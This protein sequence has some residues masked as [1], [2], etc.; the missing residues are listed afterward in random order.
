MLCADAAAGI[1]AITAAVA[2]SRADD[3]SAP[4]LIAL[5]LGLALAG[6]AF[7]IT[8]GRGLDVSGSFLSIV[9]AMALV[10][11]TGAV[12]VGV[13][14]AFVDGLRQRRPVDSLV[15]N[16]ATYAAFPHA[17]ALVLQAATAPG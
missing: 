11:P 16:V 17:G 1:S 4:V 2:L 9:L 12:A 5:L 14:S 8:T 3:W 13:V 7:Q 6:D 10:G 15:N